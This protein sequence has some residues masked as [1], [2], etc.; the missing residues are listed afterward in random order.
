MA[1]VRG[2]S[3]KI[4]A[5]FWD[6]ETGDPATPQE[7]TLTVVRPSGSTDIYTRSG[8]DILDDDK[9]GSF[10]YTLETEPEAGTWRYQIEGEDN[11][12]RKIRRR[13]A[14]SVTPAL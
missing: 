8:G 7:I 12:G 1:Y 10:Y 2:T 4:E 14:I 13:R 3:V 11:V 5:D 9:P 6:P